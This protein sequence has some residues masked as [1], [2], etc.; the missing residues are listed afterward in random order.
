MAKLEWYWIAI[1]LV[2]IGIFI[3]HGIPQGQYMYLTPTQANCDAK[4]ITDRGQYADGSFPTSCVQ[5]TSSMV[6]CDTAC[7]GTYS[8]WVE[9]GD[10]GQWSFVAM[11]RM[12]SEPNPYCGYSAADKTSFKCYFHCVHNQV[13]DDSK[14]AVA[15]VDTDG[16]NNPLV[17]GRVIQSSGTYVDNCMANGQLSEWYCGTGGLQQSIQTCPAGTSCVGTTSFTGSPAAYCSSGTCDST[18]LKTAASNAISTWVSSGTAANKQAASN[19][20]LAW[21]Q[22]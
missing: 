12:T 1:P 19:A 3:W 18:A 5:I 21:T 4:L 6:D 8:T 7:G 22:C 14:C 9:S 17:A 13:F 10:V 2:I 11:Q 16:G 15:C 20:I